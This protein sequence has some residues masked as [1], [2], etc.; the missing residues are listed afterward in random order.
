MLRLARDRSGP[1]RIDDYQG[2]TGEVAEGVRQ[3]GIRSSAGVPIVVSGRLWGAIVA[4]SDEQL[5]VDVELRLADFTGLLGTAIGNA[6]SRE[7]L[8]ELAGEQAALRRVATLVATDE[9]LTRVFA[10]VAEE[11]GRLLGT[12]DCLLLR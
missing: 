2:L 3:A 11:A 4:S 6:E 9:S 1:A 12:L 7:A 8:A 10:K 5:A